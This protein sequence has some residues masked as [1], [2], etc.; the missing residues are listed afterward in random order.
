MIYEKPEPIADFED[1]R[2]VPGRISAD[3]SVVRRLDLEVAA[4]AGA[5]LHDAGV[6]ALTISLMHSYANPDQ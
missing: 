3:G 1:T 5:E 6:E 4:A 2:E